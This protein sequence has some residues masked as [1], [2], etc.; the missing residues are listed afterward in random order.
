MDNKD[1]LKLGLINLLLAIWLIISIAT[2]SAVWTFVP[3]IEFVLSAIALL[4]I[5]VFAI[6]KLF[7]FWNKR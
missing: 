6:Y 3:E 1:R 7:R 5:N 4:G 2:C